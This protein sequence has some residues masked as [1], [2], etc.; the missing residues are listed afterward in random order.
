[1]VFF[2]K[3]LLL[4]ELEQCYIIGEVIQVFA[5]SILEAEVKV[6]YLFLNFSLGVQN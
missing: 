4:V 2:L 1:M 6:G 5:L 3:T